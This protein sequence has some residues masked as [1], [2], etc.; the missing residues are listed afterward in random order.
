[1][2]ALS[3]FSRTI[4][5]DMRKHGSPFRFV[6]GNGSNPTCSLKSFESRRKLG[7][8]RINKGFKGKTSKVDDP[9]IK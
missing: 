6:T 9:D 5:P 2:S 1:M 3:K 4:K 7:D 8:G